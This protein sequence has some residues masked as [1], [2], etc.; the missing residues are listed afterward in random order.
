M[1]VLVVVVVVAVAE[2]VVVVVGLVGLVHYY[3]SVVGGMVFVM[4]R[5]VVGMEQAVL[6]L[7]STGHVVV[8]AGGLL[9]G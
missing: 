5:L 7:M 6:C 2:I 9:M 3:Y 4:A 1:R 8:V